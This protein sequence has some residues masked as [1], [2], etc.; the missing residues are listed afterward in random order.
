MDNIN[1]DME[2]KM[3]PTTPKNNAAHFLEVS[4]QLVHGHKLRF[5]E[6][7]EAN[8]LALLH[9]IRPNKLFSDKYLPVMGDNSLSGI[10][11]D[12]ISW[13]V[14]HTQAR[15]EWPWPA[16]LVGV[17]IITKAA[18]EKAIGAELE[19]IRRRMQSNNAGE[20][21][22]AYW[23]ALMTD[24]TDFYFRV[25]SQSLI[26]M[27]KLQIPKVLGEIPALHAVGS[28]GGAVVLNM[29]NVAC[30]TAYPGPDEYS[31]TT[32]PLHRAP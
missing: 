15:L 17:D 31:L 16:H 26:R 9:R 18:F 30:W 23:H 2:T 7:D 8:A 20:P 13:I 27:D 14:F 32:W 21:M 19:D 3:S 22:K 12:K 5:F 1:R 29:A 4:I 11:S 6:P 10:S 24:G 25:H 28:R